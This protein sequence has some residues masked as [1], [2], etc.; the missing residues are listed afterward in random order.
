MGCS[1]PRYHTHTGVIVAWQ[2]VSHKIIPQK[3]SSEE[4]AMSLPARRTVRSAVNKEA[5]GMPVIYKLG[6]IGGIT[7][8][9][10]TNN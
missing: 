3:P 9:Q 2:W 7:R 5:Y 8:T 4:S 6:G 1:S 10:N